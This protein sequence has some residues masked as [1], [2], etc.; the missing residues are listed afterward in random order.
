MAEPLY[1][2]TPFLQ[3]IVEKDTGSLE[4]AISDF[5]NDRPRPGQ[6]MH[7]TDNHIIKILETACRNPEDLGHEKA[8]TGALTSLWML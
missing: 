6:P 3:E 8:V 7:Y 2:R 4:K 1:K 5:L